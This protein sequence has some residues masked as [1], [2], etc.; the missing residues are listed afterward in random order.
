MK[1]FFDRFGATFCG[2]CLHFIFSYKIY[3]DFDFFNF[4]ACLP[5]GSDFVYYELKSKLIGDELL[6]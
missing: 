5:E 4:H 1:D 3:G 2:K 6:N